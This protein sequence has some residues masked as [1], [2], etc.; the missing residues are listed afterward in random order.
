M[1]RN[2][3]VVLSLVE[4]I[5]MMIFLLCELGDVLLAGLLLSYLAT[6]LTIFKTS[7]LLLFSDFILLKLLQIVSLTFSDL[8]PFQVNLQLAV[9]VM[10]K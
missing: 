1:I 9:M 8:V 4:M 6:I 5:V 3:W 2:M 7:E 10:H